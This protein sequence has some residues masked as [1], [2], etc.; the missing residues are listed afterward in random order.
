MFRSFSQSRSGNFA[1]IAAVAAPLLLG[2]T[3]GAVDLYIHQN[4]ASELQAAADAAALAAAAE[5]GMKGWGQ[6][7]AAEIVASVIESNLSN[8]F[9]GASF[10]HQVAVS[11]KDRRIEVTLTQ[12]HFGYFFLGYFTGSPQIAVSSVAQAAGQDT[13]CILVQEPKD[14]EAFKMSG[15][16]R[17]T[18]S[19][20]S[21]Y[22]NSADS[23]G[24]AARD[25]SRLKAKL[26]CSGGGYAGT[27]LN[28]SPVPLTDCPFLR[29]PLA[30][31]AA[32][33]DQAVGG[34]ACAH[35][36]LKLDGVKKTLKPG[37]YCGGLEIK[38]GAEATF[39]PGVYVVKDGALT[40]KEASALKGE[41]VGFV[42]L[43]DKATLALKN[44]TT[45]ALSAPASGPMAGILAYAQPVAGKSRDFKIESRNAQKLVGT[46]YL[47][48]DR[49][50]IGGDQDGD[51]VCDVGVGEVPIVG[52]TLCESDIGAASSWT[53]I[54]AD[55]LVVTSGATLVLNSDYEG[56]DV[57]VPQ[58]LGHKSQA[59]T[60]A[61]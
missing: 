37:V 50:I 44:D 32:L 21:A 16:S 14:G 42:F 22:A 51:G 15:L 47:P 57:P 3:G 5:A 43:G 19:G 58:G 11:E 30:K 61:K 7:S 53:A 38:G 39:E 46:V 28:F 49:L 41:G 17:V 2:L 26:T 55:K 20:C 12:D 25:L 45:V 10:A 23:K 35:N 34:Q 4:H 1:P 27:L 29:D 54:V 33:V 56:S 31:R 6:A 59:I 18:A 24:I 36:K 48:N 40:V 52:Q 9:G 60:L 8:R 13:L